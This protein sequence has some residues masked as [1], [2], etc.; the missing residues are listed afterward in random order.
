MGHSMTRR[1]IIPYN[2]NLVPLAKQLRQNMT[3][4]EVLLWNHLKQKQM[5]GYD[6]DR[7]RPIDEYIVDFY[8]KDL[9][10][11]IEIDG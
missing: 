4:A 8:C 1:N 6:F 11:A 5:R 3:L 7:Q 2:P 10:L 9:M